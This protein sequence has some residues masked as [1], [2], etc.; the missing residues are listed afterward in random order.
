[1]A[2]RA[3]QNGVEAIL[4]DP[5]NSPALSE[6]NTSSLAEPHRHLLQVAIKEILKT[7]L[8]EN[9]YAQII[10]GLP[11]AESLKEF[12]DFYPTHPS[13]ALGHHAVTDEALEQ[14]RQWRND[15]DMKSL[16]F[17]SSVRP[18]LPYHA[19]HLCISVFLPVPDHVKVGP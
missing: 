7:P 5:S 16:V 10:D 1:M 6:A 17:K 11:T 3:I 2:Y 19:R 4:A 15:L 12:H 9:A 8:A 13:I 18:P 14:A